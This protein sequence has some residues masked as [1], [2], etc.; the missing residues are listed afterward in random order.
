M[1]SSGARSRTPGRGEAH[2]PMTAEDSIP[3]ADS[4]VE[5]T[6]LASIDGL[7][8]GDSIAVSAALV[9][10]KTISAAVRAAQYARLDELRAL[11]DSGA[12][13]ANTK[14]TEDCTL[15]Q[16]A[17]IN[18]RV[19]IVQELVDRGGDVNATGGFLKETALSWAV[20][21]GALEVVVSLI[22][23]GAD[24]HLMGTEGLN[25]LHLALQFKHAD[26]V[27]FLCSSHRSIL[28]TPTA[29]DKASLTPLMF[30]VHHW[31]RQ[32]A[33]REGAR[34][35]VD[36]IRALIAFGAN[37]NASSK[38]TGDTAL[39]L[40]VR[41]KSD[42]DAHTIFRELVDH[43]AR[44]DIQNAAGDTPASLAKQRPRKSLDAPIRR[45]S[46]RGRIPDATGFWSPW[47]QIAA[48]ASLTSAFGW[49]VGCGAFA[50]ACAGL[51]TAAGATRGT[52][53][54]I[55]HGFAAGSIFFIVTSG[56]VYLSDQVSILFK[57]WYCCSVGMLVYFFC[58]TTISNPGYVRS[59][60]NQ[61]TRGNEGA[62]GIEGGGDGIEA[63]L[64][65][66]SDNQRLVLART[67]DPEYNH[68]A[69]ASQLVQSLALKGEL[70]ASLI[71][72]TC[73]IEKPPRSK[74]C[75]LCGYC[76]Q[77][78]DHHC[79]FVN[80]CVGRDNIGYFMGFIIFCTLAIG[81]HLCVA[82]PFI[83]NTC[84]GEARY[85]KYFGDKLSCN[86]ERTPNALLVITGLAVV[87][88]VWITLLGVAQLSQ[89]YS[90]ITTYE[91]I[92]GEKPKSSHASCSRGCQNIRDVLRGRSTAVDDDALAVRDN[93]VRA[94]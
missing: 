79:P 76:I 81:S 9:D 89:I 78:F 14:D 74:H 38:G 91:A 10:E 12:I 21:Q 4:S 23:N 90:D 71:C 88:F 62:T 80:T 20:R 18:N 25:A 40:A 77:R 86:L 49:L 85:D 6:D 19:A 56:Y 44:L 63:S 93:G 83:W 67:A 8:D 65:S 69:A 35:V 92:R 33:S 34:K 11:L 28:D 61:W 84:A 42:S 31:S 43:G 82:V 94:V 87:H 55:Q 48:G 58:K 51:S 17:A 66:G 70:H 5:T 50:V 41:M 57:G 3:L 30:L 47:M 75:P 46:L 2:H 24:P 60:T 1:W 72:H 64:L 15:M 68:W 29:T 37:V 73:L 22:Q 59:S 16:W 13:S 36:L 26:I 54:N 52:E 53:R 27:L 45:E 7:I 39:H 32:R